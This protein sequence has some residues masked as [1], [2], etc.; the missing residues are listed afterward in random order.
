M[1]FEKMADEMLQGLEAMARNRPHK[2][3]SELSQG[4][5]FLLGYLLSTGGVARSSELSEA[6]GTSTARIAAA[7]KSMERKG[8]VYRESDQTDHRRTMVHL[9]SAGKEYALDYRTR[10]RNALKELLE[11]LGEEDT[12]EYLRITKR[13][14]QIITRLQAKWKTN[15]NLKE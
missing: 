14:N 12:A 3:I 7:V 5:T 15:F 10:A 4:E 13:V 6:M 1:N 8:W 2:L 9:T 11:E